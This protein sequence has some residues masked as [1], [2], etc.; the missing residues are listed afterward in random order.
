MHQMH[1]RNFTVL[2]MIMLLTA[3]GKDEFP[4]SN[5]YDMNNSNTGLPIVGDGYFTGN[6]PSYL[7]NGEIINTGGLPLE[8]YGVCYNFS[9]NPSLAFNVLDGSG[10]QSNYTCNLPTLLTGY[11]YYF[12]S[13][14]VNAKG[15]IYGKEISIQP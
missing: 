15:V 1:Y 12:K 4:Y 5:P 10:E 3:C 2:I 7:F 9:G 11:T 8:R 14:A 6:Y 13:F